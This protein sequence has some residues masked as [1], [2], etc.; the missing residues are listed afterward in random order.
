MRCN[1]LTQLRIFEPD[2]ARGHL[3]DECSTVTVEKT[4]A[5]D[6]TAEPAP[7]SGNEERAAPT[8]TAFGVHTLGGERG[9]FF[10]VGFM[11]VEGT[12][13]VVE[14]VAGEAA[15]CTGELQGFVDDAGEFCGGAAVEAPLKIGIPAGVLDPGTEIPGA[16]RDFVDFAV[17]LTLFPFE[18]REVEIAAELFVGVHRENP[19]VGGGIGGEVFLL[20]V[21]GPVVDDEGCAVLE[22]DFF[23]A[24]TAAGIDDDD[25]VGDAA[26]R[27]E[28]A[29]E[30]GFFV[31]SDDAGGDAVHWRERGC[32]EVE[33]VSHNETLVMRAELR[34]LEPKSLGFESEAERGF[35]DAEFGALAEHG[36][37]DALFFE[38]GA[39]GGVEVAE[40]DVVFPDFDDAVVARDLGIL[41]GDVSA[42]AADDDA[43][44]FQRVSSACVGASDDG[45]DDGF[46]PRENGSGVLH[47]E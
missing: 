20:A 41:Q 9:V 1:Q 37:A 10:D 3:C 29:G 6:K 22:C 17:G 45:E 34:L 12:D 24:V 26:E 18:E 4:E 25:F 47:D 42:L 28:G 27:G 5:E 16:T 36:G 30:I 19:L 33:S 43:R 2:S 38:E 14:D 39:I 46:R 31:E 13:G 7:G 40:V 11:L 32:G 21:V 35:A 44:F 23:G 8:A 15:W